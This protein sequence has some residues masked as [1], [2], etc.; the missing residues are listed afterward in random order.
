MCHQIEALQ[1]EGID[2]IHTKK[3]FGGGQ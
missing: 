2:I 1:S 3:V